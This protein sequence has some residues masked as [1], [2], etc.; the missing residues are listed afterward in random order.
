[1]DSVCR[2][3]KQ[4]WDMKRVVCVLVPLRKAMKGE[5]IFCVVEGKGHV[6][7]L[8][9]YWEKGGNHVDFVFMEEKGWAGVRM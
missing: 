7:V 9:V 5:N 3:G 8:R 1:M 4:C 2:T 6:R